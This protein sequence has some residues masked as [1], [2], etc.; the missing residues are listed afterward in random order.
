[1]VLEIFSARF[2]EARLEQ[3]LVQAD[4]AGLLGVRSGAVVSYE[5]GDYLPK[6]AMLEKI[7]EVTGKPVAWFFTPGAQPLDRQPGRPRSRQ[8][9]H[10]D[11]R[12]TIGA[13]L[14]AAREEVKA[15]PQDVMMALKAQGVNVSSKDVE[16]WES[17]ES[18]A[19][20]Y[21]PMLET[22]YGKPEGYFVGATF[23]VNRA[24]RTA[25][26]TPAEDRKA[27][28]RKTSKRDTPNRGLKVG[29]GDR[30]KWSQIQ[31]HSDV[32]DAEAA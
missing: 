6:P 7:S 12:R 30:Y 4:I 29:V 18:L 16:R 24:N 32:R 10:M 1:M 9:L 23:G 5:A 14:R 25:K 27:T 19:T 11:A 22:L 13:L 15:R 28:P 8:E 20:D 17:G 3:G 31:C 2:R 26:I 21:Y